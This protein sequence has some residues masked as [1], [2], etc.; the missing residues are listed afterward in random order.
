MVLKELRQGL[1]RG[2][3][4]I[5]F[6][7]IHFF[8]IAS[9]DME[10][11]TDVELA[12]NQY[13]GVMQIGLFFEYTPFWWVVGGIC[14]VLMPLGGIVL[15]DQELDEGNY[16]LLHMTELSR[17]Q[18]VIGK[19]LSI[20]GVTL[21]TLSSLLPYLIV[22][23]FVG[24][25]DVWRN[26]ALMMTVVMASAMVASGAIGASSFKNPFAKIGVFLLY[27]LS[28]AGSGSIVLIPSALQA[29]NCGVFYHLNV[30][31]FFLCYVLLG[32]VIARSRIRLVLHQYEMKP[33]W[34]TLILLVAGPMI[35]GMSSLFTA[36]WLGGIGCLFITYMARYVDIS[37]R[38]PSWQAL[39]KLNTPPA[40]S[41]IS[42]LGPKV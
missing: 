12:S 18:V 37:P 33:T 24:G 15:M 6:M 21:L 27:L 23:Y 36:G 41:E 35:I 39:P 31:A 7:G 29:G 9:L 5:P 8:A 38:A 2:T 17:W 16:E 32:L 26:I 4:L 42:K 22:R 11:F 28:M 10:F 1:R 25:M 20:W 3:F 13:T 40:R 34:M 14:M 30:V 19:L